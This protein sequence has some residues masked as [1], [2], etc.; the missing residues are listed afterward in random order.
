MDGEED[1]SLWERIKDTFS[2]DTYDSE[3]AT[4]ENDP[5][6]QYRGDISA[7]V[8]FPLCLLG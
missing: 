7:L 5:L 8:L 4:P 3:T 2:F 6:Y 1:R